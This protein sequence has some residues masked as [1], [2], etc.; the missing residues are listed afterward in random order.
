MPLGF[1]YVKNICDK[2]KYKVL[3]Y[4]R[5]DLMFDVTVIGAGVTGC[6]IARSLSRFQIKTLLLDKASDVAE[7]S[8][9][10][11]SGIVHAGYDA[12]PGTLRAKLNVMGNTMMN[13]IVYELSVNYSQIGSL[14]VAFNQE[15]VNSLEQLLKRGQQNGIQ[16]LELVT[17]KERLRKLEPNLT[18]EALAALY[19]PTAGIICPYG[20]ALAACENAV[21]NGVQLKLETEVISITKQSDVFIINTSKGEFPSRYVINAAG[22]YSDDISAMVEEKWFSIKPRLGQYLLLDKRCGRLSCKTIFG[23][24]N[25]LGKGI[26]VTPTVDDNL[27]LGPTSEEHQD[28][29]L[30]DTS[31]EG[32][33][34]ILRSAKRMIPEINPRDVI[35]SF[36]G[37]RATPDTGDFII[38]ASEQV[39]G[40]IHAAGIDSPGLTAAP[41]IAQRVVEILYEQGLKLV[42]KEDYSPIRKPHINFSKLTND[43]KAQFVKSNPLYGHVICRCE[44][45]TEAEIIEAINSVVGARTIDAIKR[46][47]RATSGRCQGEFCT[48]RIAEILSRELSIPLNKVTKKG[49]GSEILIEKLKCGEQ[50][51]F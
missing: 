34:S 23:T 7:G 45:V 19:A 8:T 49:A 10:A 31:R 41:A 42:L 4:T 6:L 35:T 37:I 51:G 36:S 11:N 30:P 25:E 1:L 24:P 28:K 18:N 21:E 2:I 5:G 26:L 29:A 15:E 27:L 3:Y 16:H 14:V 32:T 17:S 50:E 12:K 46:R 13:N 40:L 47:V 33:E 22:L 20:L 39:H 48:P 9:K 38:Q 43:E 44:T